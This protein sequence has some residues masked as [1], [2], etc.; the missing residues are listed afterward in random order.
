[1]FR[2]DA[3]LGGAQGFLNV[4]PSRF[5]AAQS[6]PL[7]SRT[8]CSLS[9]QFF[10]AARVMS[11]CAASFATPIGYQTNTFVYGARG[12]KDMDFV[13]VGLPFNLLFRAP[14]LSWS[15][16][17][18]RSDRWPERGDGSVG[19]ARHL[20]PAQQVVEPVGHVHRHLERGLIEDRF[21]P[22]LVAEE[23]RISDRGVDVGGLRMLIHGAYPGLWRRS[24]VEPDRLFC[25]QGMGAYREATAKSF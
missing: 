16:C 12:Y 13:K 11:G 8:P 6:A 17:S 24:G 14:R 1:V 9:S 2:I 7:L 15:R 4:R 3:G 19:E 18:G 5:T 21:R 22:E 25:P 23:A 20:G 10:S